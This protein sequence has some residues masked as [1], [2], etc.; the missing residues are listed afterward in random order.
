MIHTLDG[1]TV[2]VGKIGGIGIYWRRRDAHSHPGRRASAMRRIVLLVTGVFL[3]ISTAFGLAVLIAHGRMPLF[4]PFLLLLLAAFPAALLDAALA[5]AFDGRRTAAEKM[6]G[7]I[8][9]PIRLGHSSRAVLSML[10]IVAA[11]GILLVVVGLATGLSRGVYESQGRFYA[12]TSHG[13]TI[14]I[15]H[16][17]FY[18][19]MR[20]ALHFESGMLVLMFTFLFAFALA[21]DDRKSFHVIP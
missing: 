11:F 21:A 19:M 9:L 16:D 3:A 10:A 15:S 20:G 17:A 18:R 12:T 8:E 1:G 4:D 7:L 5:G 6:R 14:A 2:P 13:T